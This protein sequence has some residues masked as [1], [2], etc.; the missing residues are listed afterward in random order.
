MAEL[1]RVP[2]NEPVVLPNHL[3]HLQQAL[4]APRPTRHF[5]GLGPFT[6]RCES[7]LDALN[8]GRNFI[9]SSA[10]HALEMMPILLRIEPGDEVIL[11]SYTFVSTAN[12]FLLRGARLRFVDNDEFGNIR[13]SE[14]ERLLGPRTKA[15]VA[16]HYAG[17][18]AD[19]DSLLEICAKAGVAL[20][21]DAAQAIGAAYKG[22]P[23]GTIGRFGCYS[24]HET[25]N[26]TSGEGGA[27]IIGSPSSFPEEAERAEVIREKGT[28]R[29]R[30]IRGLVDKYTWVDIGSSFVLSDLNAAYLLPQLERLNEIQGRRKTIWTAYQEALESPLAQIDA[31][32]LHTPSHNTPNWHLFG[33]LFPAT[34][35]RDSFIAFMRDSG[36]LT[37]FHYVALH[38]SPFGLELSNE[39]TERLPN[40]DL[41]STCLARL[42]LF[43]NLEDHELTYVIDRAIAWIRAQ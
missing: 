5:A 34:A 40:C 7:A 8:G 37:P 15:V 20:V 12:A 13:I 22:R 28:N 29:R 2:F 1:L 24:F 35:L 14:V 33:I 42:P 21:E 17:A 18:S 43:Y 3:D 38:S 23:L 25:K 9:V 39:K 11:P 16:V 30:F 19:M 31:R 32:I 26:V 41:F 10:T 4:H 27:L 6:R 36:I